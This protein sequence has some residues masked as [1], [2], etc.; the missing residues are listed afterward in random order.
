MTS[1]SFFS[2]YLSISSFLSSLTYFF[3]TASTE[4]RCVTEA[5]LTTYIDWSV[6]LW[7]LCITFNVAQKVWRL[8]HRKIDGAG[9]SRRLTGDQ[10]LVRERKIELC[11]MAVG[12]FLP[13]GIASIPVLN[14]GVYGPAGQVKLTEI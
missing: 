13:L 11:Y 3:S 12:W 2:L 9:E 10:L 1:I 7:I 8:V 5:F 14:G 4:K 6:L